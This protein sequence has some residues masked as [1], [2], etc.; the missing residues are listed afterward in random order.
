MRAQSPMGFWSKIQGL[1]SR[2]VLISNDT[3]L[4]PRNVSKFPG[5][6]KFL[7]AGCEG[8]Q[9]DG[10][11]EGRR[12]GETERQRDREIEGRRDFEDVTSLFPLSLRLS[13]SPSNARR[14]KPHQSS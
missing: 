6:H 13:V 14:S 1:T 12:D 3:C 8:R 11:M 9:R 10:G 7:R 4:D 5:D 2:L